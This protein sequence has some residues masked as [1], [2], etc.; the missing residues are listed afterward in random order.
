MKKRTLSLEILFFEDVMDHQREPIHP[1]PNLTKEIPF[2]FYS[3][4]CPSTQTFR[5]FNK[6]FILTKNRN[7]CSHR[8]SFKNHMVNSIMH[9]GGK[10]L[11]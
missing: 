7:N 10:N 4:R 11:K 3:E 6:M 1:Y 9:S 2:S 8:R 5:D